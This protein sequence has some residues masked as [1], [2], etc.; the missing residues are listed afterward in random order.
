[1]SGSDIHELYAIRYGYHERHANENYIGGDP[2]DL[3]QPLAYFVWVITGPQGTF[4]VDT[5]FDEQMAR[6][7][8]RR[9][10]DPPGHGLKALDVNPE[11]VKQVILS[12]LH[13]DHSGN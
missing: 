2:H 6:K 12:H 9:I 11:A 13:Y 3:V 8:Q 10:V 7:R 1:M 4:V 5:G